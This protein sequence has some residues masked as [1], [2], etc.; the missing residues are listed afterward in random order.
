MAIRK[1][2]LSDG[3]TRWE[4]I[5]QRAGRGSQMIRRRFD[6][7]PEAVAFASEFEVKKR[8]EQVLRSQGIVEPEETTFAREADY[9]LSRKRLE[10]SPGYLKRV[11]GIIRD[12]KVDYAECPPMRL[13][14][15]TLGEVQTKFL[16]KG[17]KPG[18]VNRITEV[19]KAILNHSAEHRRIPYNPAAA[20][21]KL[22]AE[23][24]RIRFW[25][26]AEAQ[27][28]LDFALK[29]YPKG[30]PQHWTYLV[31]LLALN[32]GLRAGEIW[33]LK[34]GDLLFDEGL[35][36]VKRQLDRVVSETRTTK[37][38]AER[39]VPL[40]GLLSVALRE[41]V[42][43][44]RLGKDAFVFQNAAG[45]AVCHDNFRQR[46][47]AQDVRRWGIS[48]IRFHDLR[49]TAAT[50]MI[51]RG[52]EPTLVQ[53]ILGHESITTTMIYVHVLGASLKRAAQVFSLAPAPMPESEK[54][55]NAA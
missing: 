54:S 48:V 53:E 43:G 49:H 40:N 13:H 19:V 32:T 34:A 45:E 50:L 47:F 3:T 24:T 17:L 52:L 41:W 10:C 16:A 44:R 39:M 15:G 11:E 33:G 28:F 37:G 23:K 46:V 38:R 8:Q 25:S 5:S 36:H 9:W 30:S 18:S 21:K 12:L 29:K 26:E 42:S 31:Y 4:V 51:A 6:T 7:K 2:Q 55:P 20:M 22:R 1:V 35:I 14:P 27:G